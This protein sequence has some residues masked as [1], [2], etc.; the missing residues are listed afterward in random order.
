MPYDPQ[1]PRQG[2]AEAIAIARARAKAKAASGGAPPVWSPPPILAEGTRQMPG[3]VP[4]D[5]RSTTERVSAAAANAIDALTGGSLDELAGLT[6]GIEGLFNRGALGV[7]PEARAGY[8]GMNLLRKEGAQYDP[9]GTRLA[10]SGGTVA[11][12]LASL[13]ASGGPQTLAAATKLGIKMGATQGALSDGDLAERAK[14]TAIGGVIGGAIPPV[15]AG[16]L[17]LGGKT[18]GVPQVMQHLFGDAVGVRGEANQVIADRMAMDKASGIVNPMVRDASVPSLAIDQG[19]AAVQGLAKG[20]LRSPGEG[21]AILGNALERRGEQMRP[22]V[23]AALEKRI[24]LNGD[25]AKTVLTDLADEQTAFAR[26][27]E[28]AQTHQKAVNAAA[29]ANV[30]TQPGSP[31]LSAA[32]Q[33]EAGDIPNGIAILRDVMD[34]SRREMDAAYTAARAATNGFAVESPTFNAI[35]KTPIGKQAWEYAQIARKNT[36]A[37]LPTVERALPT[38]GISPERLA[39]INK[40]AA[41]RGLPPIAGQTET[42]PVPDPEAIHLMKRYF[43][44]VARMGK[45]DGAQGLQA[46]RASGALEQWGNI[47]NEILDPAWRN[48]DDIASKMF[49]LRRAGKFALDAARS[50]ANPGSKRALTLSIDAVKER[51]SSMSPEERAVFDP[52][53]KFAVSARLQKTGVASARASLVNP[54]SDLAQLVT[55][56]TGSAD[57]PYRMAAAV[58]KVPRGVAPTIAM[59]V[60]SP[61]LRAAERGLSA[62]TTPAEATGA[63][64]GRTLPVLARDVANMSQAERGLFGTTAAANLRQ[65]WEGVPLGTRS[66]GLFFAKSPERVE[67]VGFAFPN[68]GAEKAFQ[69]TV[70]AWDDVQ[71]LKNRLMGGSDTAANLAESAS[72]AP[73]FE[74]AVADYSTMGAGYATRR[75]FGR[76]GQ[77]Q[78]AA[79]RQEVDR[80]VSR[81]LAKEGG[82]LSDAEAAAKARQILARVRYRLGNGL[83][84]LA[85]DQAIFDRQR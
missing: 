74:K 18:P 53:F 15:V 80:E 56:A 13:G 22:A 78:A 75:V 35:I 6:G 77:Q 65:A 17:W 19:G 62:L 4:V 3:G 14:S 46:A 38:N 26:A 79:A 31:E 70:A 41:A 49:D 28:L 55:I 69:N 45:A 11:G 81:I 27:E 71:A 30:P 84:L 63:N 8:E 25:A 39:E 61:E 9:I 10:R 44:D 50:T 59:P 57:A 60:K 58:A 47:R 73:E 36:G 54:E 52:M 48:A 5:P 82:K 51:V 34:Q 32:F 64:A 1:D 12:L 67:Q 24:G 7:V 40:L 83:G 23:T 76:I 33:S 72:R 16:A 29:R 85:S 21:R 20:I 37:A 43:A 68:K 66:P 42:V 2:D